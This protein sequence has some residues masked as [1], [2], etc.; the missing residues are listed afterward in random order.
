[1]FDLDGFKAYNDTFG[2]PGGDLL[3]SRLSH[4]FKAAISTYGRAYRLGETSSAPCSGAIAASRWS[5]PA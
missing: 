2:H 3:L 5:N 4:A 1:M